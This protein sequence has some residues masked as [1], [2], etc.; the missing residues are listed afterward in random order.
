MNKRFKNYALW[1][2]I[3]ALVALLPDA[4]GTYDINLILPGNYGKLVEMILYILVL[5]GVINDPTT[6]RKDWLDD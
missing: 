4:L 2:A 5:A 1:V 6:E 3:F